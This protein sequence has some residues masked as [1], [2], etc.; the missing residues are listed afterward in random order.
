[1]MKRDGSLNH[2]LE[3]QFF[4]PTHFAHPTFFPGIVC[5]MNLAGVVKIDS[6]E[7]FDRIG[8]DVLFVVCGSHVALNASRSF[9]E[10]SS[11]NYFCSGGAITSGANNR[12][13]KW[14]N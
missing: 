2:C 7:I 10:K 5:S 1:M 9:S 4:L 3:E 6:G 12:R 8:G 11:C 13:S 14:I